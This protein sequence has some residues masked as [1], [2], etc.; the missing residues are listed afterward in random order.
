MG[1]FDHVRLDTSIKLPDTEDTLGGFQTKA[2]DCCFDTYVITAEGR[3]LREG[4]GWLKEED[5]EATPIDTEF[6]GILNFYT[7][8]DERKYNIEKREYSPGRHEWF[9]FDAKFTDGNLVEIKR[10]P[11]WVDNA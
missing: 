8:I 1:C 5:Y 11:G 4:G 6:H 2:F 3:L 9:E 7:H 10:L